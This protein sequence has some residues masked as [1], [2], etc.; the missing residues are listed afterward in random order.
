MNNHVTNKGKRNPVWIGIL[1]LSVSIIVIVAASTILYR[2]TIVLITDNLRER[3]LTISITGAANINAKDLE[4]LQVEE[5]WKKPEWGR[6]VNKLHKI[7]YGNKDIVFM[8]IFRYKK[9]NP[10]VMEFVADADSL[11][12][13]ANISNDSSRYVDVNRDGKIEADGPDK[14]QWPG[15]DYPE[16]VD[17][18]E[19]AK[20]YLGPLTSQDLYTDAYGTVLTGYAPISDDNGNVVAI[21]GTDI[22]ADDFFTI[23]RQT[24]Q[25]FIIFIAFLTSIISIL[26][27]F[28]IYAWKSYTKSLENI[29][30]QLE[31]ANEGQ[32]NLMHIINHQIKSY[33]TKARYIYDALLHDEDYGPIS[34]TAK[35]IV[36]KGYREMTDAVNFVQNFLT[37]SNI[38]RGTFIYDMQPLDFKNIVTKVFEEHKDIAKEK[39]LALEIAVEEGDYTMK[40]DAGQIA[41]VVKNLI[42][43]SIKYTRTGGIKISLDRKDNKIIFVIK[44]TGVGISDEL[45]PRLFTKGGVG[46]DSLRINVNST[47]FGLVFVKDVVN[48]HH[49]RVWAESAGVNQGSSF[50]MEL[51]IS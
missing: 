38:E 12:P 8:Y 14:L 16:A 3:I 13:Y 48:A 5:D 37:A 24:L 25:P 19:T 15:Q 18:P 6:V 43:N 9:D 4:A 21:L 23:T 17:I 34:E 28:I 7:K 51:P 40:G 33:M 29:N 49:G 2:R 27:V 39:G 1:V 42:D 35:P 45:K 22:K 10:G 44:D 26:I 36:E 46:K 31:T 20:A 11:D 32:S 47:G 41:Q 50:Y 30:I